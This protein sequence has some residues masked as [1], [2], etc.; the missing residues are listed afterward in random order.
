MSR[1]HKALAIL[2]VSTLGLWGCAKGPGGSSQER[3]KILEAKVSRLEGD[4][5]VGES[6]REQLRK[7]LTATEERLAKLQ[8]DRDDPLGRDP[9]NPCQCR[10]G[11]AD[12]FRHAAQQRLAANLDD[13]PRSADHARNGA[14]RRGAADLSRAARL[15]EPAADRERPRLVADPAHP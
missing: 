3:I 9:D 15:G 5:K 2:V 7:K 8:H 14:D 4:L 10:P 1:A 13:D 12:R 6:A 11:A